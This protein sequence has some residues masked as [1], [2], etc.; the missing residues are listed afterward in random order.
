[1]RKIYFAIYIFMSLL[2]V[3]SVSSCNKNSQSPGE[4]E[5]VQESTPTQEPSPEQEATPQAS[6]LPSPFSQIYGTWK[7]TGTIGSG[8][9]FS[10]S[11]PVEVYIGG[12]LTIRDDFIE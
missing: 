7:I 10:D 5:S 12:I 4:T 3:L 2:M 1:M 9:I 11:V 8:Y 6:Q